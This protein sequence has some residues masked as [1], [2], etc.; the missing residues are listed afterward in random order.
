M[1]IVAITAWLF[2]VPV[3]VVALLLA[4]EV[5]HEIFTQQPQQPQRRH[6]G[7]ILEHSRH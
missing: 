7:D 6:H 5:T 2:S 1:P 4:R 3:M